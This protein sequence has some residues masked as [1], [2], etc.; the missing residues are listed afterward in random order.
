MS[1]KRVILGI[2][3]A[4]FLPK[5]AFAAASDGAALFATEVSV[6][7]KCSQGYDSYTEALAALTGELNASDDRVLGFAATPTEGFYAFVRKPFSVSAPS[8]YSD[9][10]S[11]YAC[12][13]LQNTV[14]QTEN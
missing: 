6:L 10:T 3:L 12:V 13:T 7:F 14:P 5:M 1:Q 2:Y 9:K 8:F 4:M 11:Q